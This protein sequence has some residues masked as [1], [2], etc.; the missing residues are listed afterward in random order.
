MTTTQVTGGQVRI[1]Q[2]KKIGD[3]EHREVEALLTFGVDEGH[4]YQDVFD[5]AGQAV[6]EKVEQLHLGLVKRGPGRPP[7]AKNKVQETVHTAEPTQTDLEH[8]IAAAKSAPEPEKPAQAVEDI[9]PAPEPDP[10]EVVEDVQEAALPDVTDADLVSGCAQ[11]NQKLVTAGDKEGTKRI[12]ELIY[13][14][15]G[16]PPKRS[17]DIPQARRREFLA[18]LETV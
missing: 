14:Y 7:G 15:A 9:V 18:K 12:K 16:P 10:A 13:L 8:A 2:R 1:T 4:D 5:R 11:K 6:C 17:S 3:Y